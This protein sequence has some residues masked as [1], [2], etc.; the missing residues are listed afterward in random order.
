MGYVCKENVKE[1]IECIHV[2][3]AGDYYLSE[4]FIGDDKLVDIERRTSNVQHRPQAQ[5]EG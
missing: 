3:A 4:R 2:V 5:P 1:F